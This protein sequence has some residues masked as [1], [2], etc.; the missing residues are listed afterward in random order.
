MKLFFTPIG[1]I[2]AFVNITR[3]QG[4]VWSTITTY[5]ELAKDP[6]SSEMDPKKLT[7]I[8][9]AL[10]QDRNHLIHEVKVYLNIFKIILSLEFNIF[11]KPKFCHFKFHDCILW[12]INCAKEFLSGNTLTCTYITSFK[13]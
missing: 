7:K 5:I 9:N 12:N 11:K 4:R 3:W 2:S 1:T 10:F 8:E 13:F 6:K